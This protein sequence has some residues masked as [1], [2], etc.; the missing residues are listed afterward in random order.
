MSYEKYI[1]I[2]NYEPKRP[3]KYDTNGQ[4][5]ENKEKYIFLILIHYPNKKHYLFF[6]EETENE[7]LKRVK[8]ICYDKEEEINYLNVYI[9]D[10]NNLTTQHYGEYTYKGQDIKTIE[11]KHENNKTNIKLPIETWEQIAN[12]CISVAD[13][14]IINDSI[15]E[16]LRKTYFEIKNHIR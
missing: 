14:E 8:S 13:Y 10:K 9:F 5:I 15:K 16:D 2:N 4:E 6:T 11:L 3:Y 1:K 12:A 7:L